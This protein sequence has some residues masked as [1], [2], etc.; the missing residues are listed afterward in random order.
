[1]RIRFFNTYE[2]VSPFYRDLLPFLAE[3]G[4]EIEVVVSSKEYRAGRVPLAETLAHPRIRLRRIRAGQGVVNGRSQKLWVMF[5]YLIGAIFT[6]LFGRG[7]QVNLFLTQPPLFSLWG[8]VLGKLRRQPYIC[9]VMDVYP[10]VAVQDG[11]LPEKSALT[12]LLTVLSRFT[13]RQADL[14][15]V[16]G[17]CMADLLAE[18]GVHS[19]RIRIIPNWINE[20]EVYPVAKE[21]NPLRQQLGING[22]F[23]VLY[24]GNLGVSHFFDDILQA[25]A[26]L[27]ETPEIQFVFVGEGSRKQEAV[28]VKQ[29]K[30][31]DNLLILPFQ[32]AERLA[33]SLSM[34]D[35]HFICLREGFAG[36]VV[37]SKAYG[38]LGSGRPTVYQGE[39]TGEVARMITEEAAGIVVPL[40]QPEQLIAAIQNYYHDQDKARQDG[41]R[42]LALNRGK[43]SRRAA[44]ERYKQL[45]ADFAV[46]Q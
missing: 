11:L 1:M 38:A 26:Q 14:V 6:S 25:V 32:P 13:L 19:A 35:V 46:T 22:Q 16:I 36:L 17:R 45:F 43:Y 33:E 3:Q 28:R 9:L 7:V 44:L 24:S 21:D 40:H 20:D 4:Y 10:D 30:G 18:Q 27:K 41:A 2:P 12:K 5:T 31:L 34:G 42:A 23:V 15:V 8:Y 37:P 29:E 39:V